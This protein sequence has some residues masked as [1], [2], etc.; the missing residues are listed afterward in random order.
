MI[1]M[2]V[3]GLSL[4]VITDELKDKITDGKVQKSYQPKKNQIIINI[5]NNKTNYKI[6]VNSN[7]E[8]YRLHLTD[9]SFDNPFQAPMFCM[10]L[11]KHLDGGRLLEVKQPGLERIVEFIVESRDALG[12]IVNKS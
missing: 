7:A 12:N 1:N 8:N 2:A 10:L 3:D 9:Q 5:Y 6:L 11:R 4:R